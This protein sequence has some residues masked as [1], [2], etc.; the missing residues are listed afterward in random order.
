[1][2][3]TENHNY[4]YAANT[5]DVESAGGCLSVTI[6]NHTIAI[7]IYDSKI[8][9]IDNR[10][11]HMGFPLNQGTVKDGILTCH[12][13]H[14]RF[15][16]MNGGTF[17]Q[18]AGD[19]SSFPVEIRNANEIWIDIPQVAVV[20]DSYNY[21]HQKLLENALKRNIPLMI[22]KTV[23][24][25]LDDKRNGGENT[26]N[27]KDID[28]GLL[29]AF[30][31]GLDFGS[32][33]KQSGWGQGLTIHA[34][35]M[36]IIPYLD[37]EDISY[38]L[39]HGLSAVAQDCASM[40]PRFKISPLPKP[41][42]DLHTL[43]R[44][45]RQ[46]IES[47]DAQA[48]ERCIVTAVRSGANSYQISNI[49]FAAATDHR[50]LEI[51]HVLDFTNKALESLDIIGWNN[52]DNKDLAESV[53]SSLISG[54]ANAERMEESNSWRYPVD[55]IDILEKAF[56]KLPIVLNNGIRRRGQ[57]GKDKIRKR[58]NQRRNHLMTVL[59]GDDPQL[60]VNSLLD[61]LSRGT[62]EEELASTVADTAALRIVQ[63]H[64]RNE[65]SDWD[66]VLHMFT[67]ANA[68]HQALRRTPT[69]ELLRGVFDG[70]MR[71]YLNR[72]L[73]V[74]QVPL[75]KPTTSAEER[76]TN[77]NV[78]DDDNTP[79]EDPE[80]L[81][82]EGFLS[83]LDK[84]QQVNQAGQLMMD[85]LYNNRAK[86]NQP[87][88]AIGK[89]LLREDRNFHSIQMIEAVFRQYSLAST[90]VNYPD[91]GV[92]SA[93]RTHMLVAAARYLAAHSPTMRSQGRT[94]QIANQ[95]YHGEHLFE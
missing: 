88:A 89:A 83:L 86:P 50:F 34:C 28:D 93:T 87:L 19:V 13:H 51:G 68:V 74:P 47:R 58:W 8:Y 10:C 30:H 59:L 62:S 46:F 54:Y 27:K 94:Y 90:D 53:L 1:L 21:R 60:I 63:F 9:A 92:N 18:W 70:A 12:W 16:L 44:W 3:K 67:Y 20:V 15:D 65:F 32:H 42:P 77:N 17:D 24:A 2:S 38:A 61:A 64:T 56:K 48:A 25:M 11:P 73:N 84:Q 55:L 14:A 40:P 85:Y 66:A 91:N 6:E 31:V 76:N 52:S 35:M 49:L 82:T 33:Y 26:F 22:A 95:L 69:Q 29:N 80:A 81:L 75:P 36:N 39:Y 41:W 5:K 23:I 37:A 4:V 71:I 72:F 45:F 43:K 57:A 78:V 79:K 7:F